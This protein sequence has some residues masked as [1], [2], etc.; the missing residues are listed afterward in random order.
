MVSKFLS[1]N[2]IQALPMHILPLSSGTRA[3]C[4]RLA[5]NVAGK[6]GDTRLDS[7]DAAFDGLFVACLTFIGALALALTSAT[8]D[9]FF[10]KPRCTFGGIL[11][12]LRPSILGW[13]LLL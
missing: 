10:T 1:K 6:F 11:P 13:R 12:N 7:S 3:S 8:A 4:G 5:V 2:M 9:L